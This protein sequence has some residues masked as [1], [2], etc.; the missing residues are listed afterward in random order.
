VTLVLGLGVIM[1]W[2]R[3]SPLKMGLHPGKG[4][5]HKIHNNV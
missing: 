3:L 4:I 1:W 5:N 2:A